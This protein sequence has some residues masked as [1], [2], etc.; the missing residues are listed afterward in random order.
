M[1]AGSFNPAIFHPSWISHH[2]LLPGIEADQAKVELVHD[3]MTSFAIEW[4]Q[5]QVTHDR[6]IARTNDE[7]KYS[8][9]RDLVA[10]IF[11][12]LEHTPIRSFGM[13]RTMHFSL[14][15]ESEWHRIGHTVAPVGIW[16]HTLALP[17]GLQSLSLQSARQDGLSGNINVKIEPSRRVQYGVFFEVNSHIN[18]SEEPPRLPEILSEKWES[19]MARALEIGETTI[20]KILA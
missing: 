3:E 16:E 18:L 2:G 17:I 11:Q 7:S 13:N 10:S 8:P 5:F 20:T 4:L 14:S 15:T 6:L 19:T 9:L 1:L 12:I